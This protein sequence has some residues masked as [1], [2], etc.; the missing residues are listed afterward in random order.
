MTQ[1]AQPNPST[2]SP[3][4]ANDLLRQFLAFKLANELFAIEILRV[5]NTRDYTNYSDPKC[6]SV[7]SWGHE[8]Q[9]HDC[10][11]HRPA[12]EIRVG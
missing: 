7:H 5:R 10:A 8:S 6:P 1:L 4:A 11:G 12:H 9:G 2:A 3:G